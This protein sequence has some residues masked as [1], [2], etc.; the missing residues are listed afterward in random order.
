MMDLILRGATIVTARGLIEGDVGIEGERIARIGDLGG[1][2]S[3]RELDLRGL[4]L[5]P[6]AIDSHVHFGLEMFGAKS[7]DDYYFGSRAAAHGGVTTVMD[8]TEQIP[9]ES[10]LDSF[11]RKK[12]WGLRDAVVDFLLHINVT[13]FTTDYRC[14]IRRLIDMGV[15]S[16]K[17]FT[18][19]R[20]R[21]LMARDDY[22]YDAMSVIR[23]AGGIAM[24]H[25]ENG[26]IADYLAEKF[27]DEGKT[28]P[29][30]HARSRPDFVE[31][32]A[33]SRVLYIAE[34][35]GCPVYIVHV[36][37]KKGLEEVRR[38]KSRGV[39]VY[40][41]TCPHYL[42]LTED[43]LEGEEGFQYIATPPLRKR[44]DSL[45][46][47][48]GIK[49]G[50]IDTVATDHAAYSTEQKLLGG[51]EFHRTP[52]GLPGTETLLPLLYTYGVSAGEISLSRLAELISG[53]PARIFGLRDKGRIEEGA[54]ADLVAVDPHKEVLLER[55]S[56]HG[57]TDFC[58]YHGF[59]VKGLPV[60]TLRRGELILEKGQFVGVRG[61]GSYIYQS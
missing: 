12:E 44:E 29:I 19:Y 16:F 26:D 31:A 61:K 39:R 59:K 36:S 11:E 55:D 56:L 51:K 46:L 43:K 18:A 3:K 25:C 60:F 37:T 32:E 50:T 27:I 38:A 23:D 6:G 30:Y 15:K 33:I 28:T 21:G 58:P 17:F 1:L 40:A 42:F 7:P 8:F 9:G 53:N 45:A 24:V 10:I 2:P 14:D 48:E 20:K 22:L 54:H 35:T 41:E 57:G 47:W 5:L 52:S 49:D 4:L 13:D 34:A